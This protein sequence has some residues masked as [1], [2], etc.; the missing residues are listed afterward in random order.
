MKEMPEGLEV[1][2][3][4]EAFLHHQLQRLDLME[5]NHLEQVE[6]RP[7]M[8]FWGQLRDLEIIMEQ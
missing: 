1:P 2:E 5:G 4:L 3:V 6:I 7:S 8:S